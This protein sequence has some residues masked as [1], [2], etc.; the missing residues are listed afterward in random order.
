[1]EQ[2]YK[3]LSLFD[4]IGCFPL[5]YS[6]L[7]NGLGNHHNFEYESSE[8]EDYLINILKGNFNN[9]NQLGDVSKIDFKNYYNKNNK[10]EIITMGTPCTGFSI[11]GKREG[12]ENLESK[13][14]SEGIR[15]IDEIKPKYFIWENVF[16][17]LSNNKGNEFIDV[18]TEFTRINYNVIW[19]TYDMKYFGIPQRRRRV[20]L[21]GVRNDLEQSKNLKMIDPFGF[22]NRSYSNEIMAFENK[23]NK[24]YSINEFDNE[25]YYFNRQRSDSFKAEGLASTL[26]KRDYKS[27]KDLIIFNN[28]IRRETPSERLKLQGIP[29]NWF[30]KSGVSKESSLYRANGMSLPV[31]ENVF[32]SL[33]IIDNMKQNINQNFEDLKQ[34]KKN[35][36]YLLNDIQDLKDEKIRKSGKISYSGLI[37]KNDNNQYEIHLIDSCKETKDIVSF[38][39][40]EIKTIQDIFTDNPDNKY[41]LSKKSIDGIL[42]REIESGNALP[43]RLREKIKEI[44]KI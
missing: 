28:K 11:S 15:A 18:L 33:S 43:K 41:T 31:V 42:R 13:L 4:G 37:T 2:N 38:D 39:Y 40:P 35:K 21:I 26:A 34:H 17:V 14:F 3:L 1:M 19:T 9:V 6:N 8:I 16:G 7:I 30:E 25:L 10:P 24:L 36:T 12:L 22:I 32:E 44:F 23:I 20:Y 5:A 27:F 29:Q